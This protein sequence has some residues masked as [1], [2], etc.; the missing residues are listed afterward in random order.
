MSTKKTTMQDIADELRI[1]KVSVSKAINNKSGVS[2]DLRSKILETAQ[3][4]NYSKP[5]V[6]KTFIFIAPKRFF[7][8]I[9]QF[10]STIYFKLNEYC[11]SNNSTMVLAI[12]DEM[13][14]RN[15]ILPSILKAQKY[16]GCFVE[17][18]ME[19][20]FQKALN[21]IDLPIITIDYS[22]NYLK[23]DCVVT[24]NYNIGYTATEYL[25]AKGH[26][27]IGFVGKFGMSAS[28][29]DRIFGYKRALMINS[30]V[31]KE[32]WLVQNTDLITKTY[33][34]EFDYPDIMP[35]AFV[36]HCDMAAYTLIKK[37]N[38][39]GYRIPQDISVISIDN[40]QLA[41]TCI[42]KLTDIDISLDLFV[43][44]SFAAMINRINNPSDQY[45]R[46]YVNTHL[47]ERDSVIDISTTEMVN[48][49]A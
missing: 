25:I 38:M 30:L 40:T 15:G 47:I 49:N 17:G 13:D 34:T 11:S 31:F 7:A 26:T 19:V 3:K 9:E 35:T 43:S 5:I 14:E 16:C 6:N 4:L 41:L 10:Y 1:T 42:P 27:D 32:D 22:S 12:V 39:D 44:K 36:C 2:D 46:L 8:K 33:T 20:L 24:D 48:R 28:I 23:A 45:N 18:E 37:L 21:S 29:T